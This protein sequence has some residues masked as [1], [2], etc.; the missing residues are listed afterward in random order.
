MFDSYIG[1]NVDEIAALMKLDHPSHTIAKVPQGAMI[2]MDH[3]L[4]RYR[5]WYNPD[6]KK[7]T[8]ITNG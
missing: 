4:D 2:T 7:V 1:H 3:R 6:T 8:R 5:V